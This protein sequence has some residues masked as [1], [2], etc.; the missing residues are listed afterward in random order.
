MGNWAVV[1]PNGSGVPRKS[2]IIHMDPLIERHFVLFPILENLL[3]HPCLR[4]HSPLRLPPD[5][6]IVSCKSL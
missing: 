6:W 1:R 5:N 3:D 2:G 4:L